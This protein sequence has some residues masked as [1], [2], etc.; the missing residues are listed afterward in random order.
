MMIPAIP[1]RIWSFRP[2]PVHAPVLSPHLMMCTSGWHRPTRSLIQSQL[3]TS[4]HVH[5]SGS[6]QLYRR[7]AEWLSSSVSC[8]TARTVFSEAL[9]SPSLIANKTKILNLS[10]TGW[11][12]VGIVI[13]TIA[14]VLYA[15]RINRTR[16]IG[17]TSALDRGSVPDILSVEQLVDR[18]GITPAIRAILQP[19]CDYSFYDMI[20]G[21]HGTGKTTLVRQVGHQLPG[22]IY[23]DVTPASQSDKGFAETLA[24]RCNWFPPSRSPFHTLLSWLNIAVMEV[25]DGREQLVKVWTE[26]GNQAAKFKKENARSAVLILDNINRLAENNP[27]LLNMLQDL[28]KDAADQQ[29]FTTVFVTSEGR[30]PIQMLSRSAASRLGMVLV[31]NDLNEEEAIG[32]LC[33]QKGTSTT[34]A[35]EIFRLVGGR[36]GFLKKAAGRYNAAV[37]LDDLK[38]E[39]LMEAR[40]AFRKAGIEDGG[41]FEDVGIQLAKHILENGSITRKKFYCIAGGRVQ[42]DHLLNADVFSTLPR[43]GLILFASTPVEIM[44]KELV[45]ERKN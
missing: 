21:N 26:F 15:Y 4:P 43:S 28:A 23:V 37:G 11:S 1:S 35:W 32:Y 13:C 25:P 16:E 6:G 41:E 29:L 8:I 30:A 3:P 7:T 18:K 40:S 10:K 9:E 17:L 44:A 31:I 22:V 33:N 38:A 34:V 36:V 19:S 27:A 24:N 42:G 14:N 39:F 2:T 20:V 5:R 12:L 45:L